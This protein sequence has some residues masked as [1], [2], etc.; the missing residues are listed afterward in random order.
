MKNT[1]NVRILTLPPRACWAK[2]TPIS[3]SALFGDLSSF[4]PDRSS[5]FRWQCQDAHRQNQRAEPSLHP[6]TGADMMWMELKQADPR[7]T[8]E[9]LPKSNFG[10]VRW[11]ICAL[12]FFA[13]VINYMDRQV[14]GLL[15]PDL[16]KI[17][18]W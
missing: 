8:V 15:K 9:V 2:G 11:V 17:F 12:L 16:M 18:C 3:E 4:M 7:A 1:T 13:C 10:R 6:A 14:L 5:A